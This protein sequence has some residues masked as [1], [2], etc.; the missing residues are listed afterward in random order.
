[1]RFNV[2][3]VTSKFFA[4]GEDLH[5]KM[6]VPEVTGRAAA[7]TAVGGTVAGGGRLLGGHRKKFFGGGGGGGFGRQ[8]GGQQEVEDDVGA[9][10]RDPGAELTPAGGGGGGERTDRFRPVGLFVDV[11]GQQP[12]QQQVRDNFFSDVTF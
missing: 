10:F 12:Q 2:P 9:M 6:A 11:E 1:M 8:V 5:E 4:A 7:A 3:R